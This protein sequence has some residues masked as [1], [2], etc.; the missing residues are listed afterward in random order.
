[1]RRRTLFLVEDHPV[2]RIG[3]QRLID[4][5]PDLR[6]AGSAET[7]DEALDALEELD[8]D[9][10]VVDLSLPGMDGLELVQALRQRAPEQAIVVLSAHPQERFALQAARAGAMGYLNKE[11]DPTD[12]LAALRLALDGEPAAASP[13]DGLADPVER[14]SA[15][16]RQVFELTGQGFGTR[17]VA[18]RLGIGIKTVETHKAHIKEKL[19]VRTASELAREAVAWSVARP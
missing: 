7:G 16:E 3:L 5:E 6:V 19:G 14:L 13:G 2:F 1:M 15:R 4:A 9:L 11:S 12:V 17:Q 18:A 8:V 10:V